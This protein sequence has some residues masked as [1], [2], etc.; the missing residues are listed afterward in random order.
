MRFSSSQI[1]PD[2]SKV[3]SGDSFARKRASRAGFRLFH[4]VNRPDFVHS[5]IVKCF[6]G[7]RMISR[8]SFESPA[9]TIDPTKSTID[10]TKPT[11]DT[12]KRTIESPRR[13]IDSPKSTIEPPKRT[14]DSPAGTIDPPE[15]SIDPR[16]VQSN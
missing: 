13:T 8:S 3:A 15:G 2:D 5:A 9:A 16:K 14:I 12:S 7:I 4:D 6:P 10:P 1:V 11:I